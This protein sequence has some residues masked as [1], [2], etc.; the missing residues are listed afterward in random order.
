VSDDELAYT[1]AGT[2]A[3]PVDRQRAAVARPRRARAIDRSDRPVGDLSTA[4]FAARSRQRR[5]G[6]ATPGG[7][8]WVAPDG[9]VGVWA[10]GAGGPIDGVELAT[11]R[12]WTVLAK[13]DPRLPRDRGY[14]YFPM[15]SR[16]RSLLAVAASNDEH[17][18]FRADY[19]LCVRLDPASL[20]PRERG[21]GHRARGRR[22]LS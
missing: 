5:G 6:L 13:H 21:V 17:D 1:T 2:A 20:L 8:C 4:H 3:R 10:A 11:R 18:H 9:E 19:D 12:T 14:L 7:C 16:D 15:L 22:S